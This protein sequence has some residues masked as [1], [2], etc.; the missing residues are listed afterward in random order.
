M[1]VHSVHSTNAVSNVSQTQAPDPPPPNH[2]ANSGGKAQRENA[3][4]PPA[5]PANTN[6]FQN[7]HTPTGTRV[8]ASR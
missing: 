2:A 5:Q 3:T 8:D 4:D 1:H 7:A 6:L